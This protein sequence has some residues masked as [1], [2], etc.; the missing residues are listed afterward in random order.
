MSM[1]RIY[2]AASYTHSDI[3]N[4]RHTYIIRGLL[5]GNT[6]AIVYRSYYHGTLARSVL[7]HTS[8]NARRPTIA[9]VLLQL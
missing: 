5:Y 9:C 8:L 3:A 6:I 2:R 1:I 4:Y 7:I